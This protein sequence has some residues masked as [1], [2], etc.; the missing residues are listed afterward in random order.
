MKPKCN[1]NIGNT[2]LSQVH[3]F[4]YL[5]TI[6]TSDG[7]SD[8][9]IKVR[10]AQSKHIF[11]KLKSILTNKRLALHTCIGERVMQCYVL[12]VLMYGCEAWTINKGMEKRIDALDMHVALQESI[13]DSMDCQK[14]K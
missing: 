8:I 13:K 2:I 11:M 3:K 6:I 1:I 10:M 4:K 9:E 12:P 5:R 7:K 14:V